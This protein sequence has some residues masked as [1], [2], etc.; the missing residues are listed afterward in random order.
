MDKAAFFDFLKTAND[1]GASAQDV[2]DVLK[3]ATGEEIDPAQL[4]QLMAQQSQRQPDPGAGGPPPQDPTALPPGHPAHQGHP[5]GHHGGHEQLPLSEE[6]IQEIAALIAQH[7]QELEAQG[8]GAGAPGAGG[9]PPGA[10]GPPP[11]AS[12]PPE[13]QQQMDM[14]KTSEYIGEFIKRGDEFGFTPEQSVDLYCNMLSNAYTVFKQAA[15]RE[16]A[17]TKVASF[18]D[19]ETLAYFQGAAEHAMNNKLSYEQTLDLLRKQ[20]ADQLLKEKF[21]TNK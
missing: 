8:G 19:N 7:L 21:T 10:G 17:V 5:G 6:Q 3:Q 1:E 13:A 18:V 2:A 15:D 12:L 11:G 20:G 16:E 14:A 9:P 4:Q